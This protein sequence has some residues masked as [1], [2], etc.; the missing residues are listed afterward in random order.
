MVDGDGKLVPE[1]KGRRSVRPCPVVIR[2]G[3]DIFRI[4]SILSDLFLSWDYRQGTYY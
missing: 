1:Q 3:L 2:K 4:M